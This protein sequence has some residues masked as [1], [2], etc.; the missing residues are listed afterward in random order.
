MYG[1]DFPGLDPF[2]SDDQAA[3]DSIRVK[4]PALS[5]IWLITWQLGIFELPEFQLGES[6]SIYNSSYGYLIGYS[7]FGKCDHTTA[8]G[9]MEGFSVGT[10]RK[11]SPSQ[12]PTICWQ[13]PTVGAVAN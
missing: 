2:G 6:K 9:P 1:G 5:P 10:R 7:L 12:A 11:N 3:W 13:T 4:G 8:V